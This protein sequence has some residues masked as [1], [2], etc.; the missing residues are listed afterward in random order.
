MIV[1]EPAVGITIIL[2]ASAL[3]VFVMYPLYMVLRTSLTTDGQLSLAI[4]RSLLS[5][6]Y[7]RRP[8]ANSL[9]LGLV[10]SAAGTAAGFIFAYSTTRVDVPLRGFFKLVA[11]FPMISPP[12]IMSLAAILLFGNNGLITRQVLRRAVDFKIYPIF[13]TLDG[14]E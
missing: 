12:L 7:N 3:A 8:L 5:K 4:F 11:M 6:S 1:R 9:K 13:S 14:I 10:V 2:I